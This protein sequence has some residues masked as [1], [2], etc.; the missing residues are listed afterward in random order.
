MPMFQQQALPRLHAELPHAAQPTA[1]QDQLR[2]K[3]S[4]AF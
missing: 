3:A 2:E 4:L 1:V